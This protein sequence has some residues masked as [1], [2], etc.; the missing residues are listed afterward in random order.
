LLK[1]KPLKNAVISAVSIEGKKM[2]MNLFTYHY[3]NLKK[4]ALAMAGEGSVGDT[5]KEIFDVLG[6]SLKVSNHS[7]TVPY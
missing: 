7:T 3:N 1:T 2:N 4:V 5:H 6:I